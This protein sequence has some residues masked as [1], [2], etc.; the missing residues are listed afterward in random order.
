MHKNSVKQLVKKYEVKIGAEKD[1]YQ[2]K[3]LLLNIFQTQ[4]IQVAIKK[5]QNLIHI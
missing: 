2:L 1:N 3:E 5:N 4:L